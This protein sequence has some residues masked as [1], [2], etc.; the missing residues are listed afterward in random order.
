MLGSEK[1]RTPVTGDRGVARNTP[2][3]P[4]GPPL[5]PQRGVPLSP[6]TVLPLS[7]ETGEGIPSEGIPSEVNPDKEIPHIQIRESIDRAEASENV[8]GDNLSKFEVE[9][10]KDGP[11]E[12][13]LLNMP[14][15][16]RAYATAH[17]FR[18]AT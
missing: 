8:C 1:R 4:D 12:A 15:L 9:E 16:R 11:S 14:E 6:Q 17:S 13:E 3:T 10:N 5:S 18:T 2:V 7:R